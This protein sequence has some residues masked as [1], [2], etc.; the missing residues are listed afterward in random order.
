MN[1]AADLSFDCRRDH[2]VFSLREIQSLRKRPIGAKSFV[3]IYRANVSMIRDYG[4]L[5]GCSEASVTAIGVGSD[6][7]LGMCGDSVTK[8]EFVA[9]TVKVRAR[10][11]VQL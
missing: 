6:E 8:S 4:C 11:E 3:H 7:W 1:E 9:I 10:S 5:A 2:R